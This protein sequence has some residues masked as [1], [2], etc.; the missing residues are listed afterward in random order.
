M[1]RVDTIYDVEIPEDAENVK[2]EGSTVIYRANKIIIK[3]LR[4]VDDELVLYFYQISKI[5]EKSYYKALG[6]V[7]IMNYEKTSYQI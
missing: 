7:T 5:P 4:K 1:H 3:N 6:V 2:L